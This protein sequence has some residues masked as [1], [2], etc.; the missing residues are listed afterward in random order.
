MNKHAPDGGVC[1]RED[2]GKHWG[3]VE[4]IGNGHSFNC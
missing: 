2:G 3:V 4:E 1:Q